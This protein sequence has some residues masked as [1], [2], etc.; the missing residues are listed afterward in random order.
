LS[1]S[2]YSSGK[3]SGSLEASTRGWSQRLHD[4]PC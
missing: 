1:L 2:F 4:Q 3:K